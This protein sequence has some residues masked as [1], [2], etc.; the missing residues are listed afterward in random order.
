[1]QSRETIDGGKPFDWGLTS[2]DYVTHRPGYPESFFDALR[3][4]GVVRP[5]LR[6]L[7]VATGP[8]V[9]AIPLAQLGARVTGL[10]IA[11]NQVETARTLTA[12]LGLE[13]EY[14]V[15]DAHE[16][17]LA[18][19]S[20]DLVTAS[21]C[22]HYFDTNRFA[23]ETRRLLVRG[24]RLLVASLIYLPGES[25]IA[26]ESERLILAYNPKWSG[27]GFS[28][29]L[30]VNATWADGRFRLLTFHRYVES[31]TFTRESWRGRIRACR[32]IGASLT[33]ER[34]REFDEE[35]AKL[36]DRVADTSFSIPHLIS[37]SVYVPVDTK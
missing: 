9:V 4:L 28:G 3:A 16:T 14:V 11:D 30:S 2:A 5:G 8:G 35:H 25:E 29:A 36:L 20:F 15:A 13:I 33:P 17:G 6:V 1:M 32:G 31:V 19:G 12:Q 18:A 23:D 24:G 7:D 10:D 26:A 34:I 37:F 22:V 21:M 27:A